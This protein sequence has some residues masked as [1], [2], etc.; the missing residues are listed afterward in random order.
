MGRWAV[1]C[2]LHCR[3]DGHAEVWSGALVRRAEYRLNLGTA[4]S[5]VER[6]AQLAFDMATGQ[7]QRPWLLGE[8]GSLALG[9]LFFKE[10][11][12]LGLRL[13]LGVSGRHAQLLRGQRFD[14]W[15][16]L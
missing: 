15:V 16:G 12:S 7:G 14:R 13:G 9:A 1:H 11:C 6:P 5:V 2:T 8:L 4:A 10:C 3:P